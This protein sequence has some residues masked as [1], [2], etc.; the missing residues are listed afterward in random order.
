[1][2]FHEYFPEKWNKK[3]QKN[4]GKYQKYI[5]RLFCVH[6]WGYYRLWVQLGDPQ[7]NTTSS[8]AKKKIEKSGCTWCMCCLSRS[9]WFSE[10]V[11]MSTVQIEKRSWMCLITYDKRGPLHLSHCQLGPFCQKLNPQL[12]LSFAADGTQQQVPLSLSLKIKKKEKRERK[13]NALGA[14]ALLSLRF[15]PLFIGLHGPSAS[16][17]RDQD[18][19]V[20]SFLLPSPTLSLSLE[21]NPNWKGENGISRTKAN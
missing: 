1:M 16:R 5:W 19:I 9:K 7:H 8:P 20:P 11:F 14:G 10:L 18:Q 6:F 12:F 21:F 2:N 4:K 17:W 15:P 13:R 3:G